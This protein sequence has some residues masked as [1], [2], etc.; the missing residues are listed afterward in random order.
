MSR[1]PAFLQCNRLVIGE[2]HILRSGLWILFMS[3]WILIVILDREITCYYMLLGDIF[4]L[5]KAL[6]SAICLR[7]NYVGR[8]ILVL[9]GFPIVF[10]FAMVCFY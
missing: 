3:M 2:I 10:H 9:G 1:K 8:V 4:F 6:C 7:T 5:V